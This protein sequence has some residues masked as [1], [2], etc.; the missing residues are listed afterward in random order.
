MN[1]FLGQQVRSD[2]C[3]SFVQAN[4]WSS[5]VTER[6]SHSSRPC[7]PR[8]TLDVRPLS[9]LC[10]PFVSLHAPDP[11]LRLLP[12]GHFT[13]RRPFF[14]LCPRDNCSLYPRYCTLRHFQERD[15]LSRNGHQYWSRDWSQDVH[16]HVDCLWIQSLRMASTNGNVLLLR[17]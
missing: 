10:P 8:F 6:D 16:F 2:R 14:S 1:Y 7:T 5:R 12:L 4:I 17:K 9:H 13:H 11:P 3:K 15:S